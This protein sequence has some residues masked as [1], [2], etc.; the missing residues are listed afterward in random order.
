M[1]SRDQAFLDEIGNKYWY[2]ASVDADTQIWPKK[3]EMKKPPY[4]GTGRPPKA[5]PATPAMRVD[6]FLRSADI[7]W[8]R[9]RLNDGAKGPIVAEMAFTRVYNCREKC[10]GEEVW[11]I[12]RRYENGSY[13]YLM[14]N[15]P[16]DTPLEE[17]LK[18]SVQ[19]WTIEQAFQEGKSNL[20]MADYEVRSWDGWH[21][22]MAYV[23]VAR[24]FLLELQS[25]FQT[26]DE[27]ALFTVP[28]LQKLTAHELNKN[29]PKPRILT[30][31]RYLKR[32]YTASYRSRVKQKEPFLTRLGLHT[33]FSCVLTSTLRSSPVAAT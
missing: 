20:G 24:L 9:A 15:T 30:I 18:R 21:R 26:E 6:E 28:A 11:L 33:P 8:Y 3:P 27:K 29:W 19:R 22:H 1:F 5:R 13:R 25:L 32:R 10:P 16:A 17:L 23:A 12:I 7:E 31:L 2:M 14:S 4:K